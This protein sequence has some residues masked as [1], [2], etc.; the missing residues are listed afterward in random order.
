MSQFLLAFRS[1]DS[2][3]VIWGGKERG[4]GSEGDLGIEISTFQIQLKLGKLIKKE[5]IQV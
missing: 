5:H 1:S 3:I 4:V 2:D